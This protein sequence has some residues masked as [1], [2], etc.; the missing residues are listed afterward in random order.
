METSIQ[1]AFLRFSCCVLKGYNNYLLPITKAPKNDA[2]DINSLFDIQGKDLY[3]IGKR[4]VVI[5]EK[6]NK[7][8]FQII[9]SSKFRKASINVNYIYIKIR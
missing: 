4:Y 1:E 3:T 7:M 8:L 6:A 5:V 2:T 9:A